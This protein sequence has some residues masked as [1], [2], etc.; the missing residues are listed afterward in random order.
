MLLEYTCTP[1]FFPGHGA[2]DASEKIYEFIKNIKFSD[3]EAESD[4]SEDVETACSPVA[5]D[6]VS[7]SDDVTE[8]E[9]D[10]AEVRLVLLIQLT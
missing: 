9:A 3:W 4:D 1:V 7:R 10:E 2:S 8:E 5:A 6:H